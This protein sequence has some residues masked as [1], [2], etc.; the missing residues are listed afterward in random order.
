[1]L[2]Y[3]LIYTNGKVLGSYEVIKLGSF[4]RE[5]IGTLLGNIDGITLEI[6]FGTE[7]DSLDGSFYG[8]NDGKLEGLLLGDLL[9]YND[10]KV[11]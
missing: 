1:M 8:Y 4:D 2:G 3:S 9:G 7:L 5:V 10:V 6:D 11:F